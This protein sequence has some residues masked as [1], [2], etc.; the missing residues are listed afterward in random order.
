MEKLNH[1][2]NISPALE[3]KLKAVGI[4]T[5]EK[6][7]E[8]GSRHV[9]VRIKTI[10]SSACFEMLLKLEGAVQGVRSDKL[11]D[12]TKEELKDFMSIFN[13]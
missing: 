7:R 8:K 1:L 13:Q 11:S 4:N 6:L 3:D 9:F 5:P 2:P 12:K 10:D